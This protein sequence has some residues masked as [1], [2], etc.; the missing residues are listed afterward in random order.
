MNFNLLRL[1]C[2]YAFILY[3]FIYF[4]VSC[5][6]TI[7]HSQILKVILL[8]LITQAFKSRRTITNVISFHDLQVFLCKQIFYLTLIIL[9]SCRHKRIL[10]RMNYRCTCLTPA[11]NITESYF[12]FMGV[13]IV[14]KNTN[15]I[16]YS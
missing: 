2:F 12:Y 7:F 13:R 1:F 8:V 5:K 15:F 16:I 14:N 9:H 6:L 11:L 4:R 10:H 3:I